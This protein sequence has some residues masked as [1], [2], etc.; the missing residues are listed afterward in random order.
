MTESVF[1]TSFGDKVPLNWDYLDSVAK[2]V[3]GD[4]PEQLFQ[5][6]YKTDAP[7]LSIGNFAYKHYEACMIYDAL[8]K[9]GLGLTFENMLD[10]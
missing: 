7:P 2:S 1:K 5:I 9:A 8:R 10:L 4:T 6:Q 3:R